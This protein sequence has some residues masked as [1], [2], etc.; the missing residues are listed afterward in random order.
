VLQRG[1]NDNQKDNQTEQESAKDVQLKTSPFGASPLKADP[2]VRQTV[3]GQAKL[4]IGKANDKYEVE[5]DRV[6]DKVVSKNNA[7][8]PPVQKK[9]AGGP[10][11]SEGAKEEDVQMKSAPEQ[12]TEIQ[13]KPISDSITKGIQLKPI[14]PTEDAEV[15]KME[16]E[17]EGEAEVQTKLDAST[18]APE[19]IQ[20]AEA[21]AEE[22]DLQKTAIQTKC[23]SCGKEES[24][25]KLNIQQKCA[26]CEGE[27][28]SVQKMDAEL[29]GEA[30]VQTKLDASTEAPEN[31]QKAEAPAEESDLQKTAIQ[32]KCSSCGKTESAE[33]LNVQQKCSS[34]EGEEKSVQKMET[35]DEKSEVQTKS[36]RASNSGAD[37]ESSLKSSKGKGSAMDDNTRS[38]MESG[39]GADFSGVRIH[40]DS[41]A[42]QMNK[43]LGSQAFAN[44]SD[45]YFNEGKYNPSSNSGQHLLAHELTHTV[46]QG[47]SPKAVQQKADEVQRQESSTESEQ[48]EDKIQANSIQKKDDPC[49]PP[50]DP[51]PVEKGKYN[52][53][54]KAQNCNTCY[55]TPIKPS[56]N[57]PEP[58]GD[59]KKKDVEAKAA[60]SADERQKAAPN[61]R[62]DSQVNTT[63]EPAP[64]TDPKKICEEREAKQQAKEKAKGKGAGALL[65][66]AANAA[67]EG[68]EAG[69]KGKK[70]KK[71][72]LSLSDLADQKS[73]EKREP[74]VPKGA[75]ASKPLVIEKNRNAGQANA[76][77]AQA[78]A[79][80]N[81][82]LGLGSQNVYFKPN[83]NGSSNDVDQ[84]ASSFIKTRSEKAAETIQQGHASILGV[85]ELTSKKKKVLQAEFNSKRQKSKA[86]FGIK[87]FQATLQ[88]TQSKLS[89]HKQYLQTVAQIQMKALIDSMFLRMKFQKDSERIAIE[90]KKYGTSVDA[91]FKKSH[92]QHISKGNEY[93]LKSYN[94]G[95]TMSQEYKHANN[96]G[97]CAYDKNKVKKGDADGF[98]D[99]YLTINRYEAR[100]ESALETGKQYQEGMQTQSRDVADKL[101]CQ[102]P[103][104]MMLAD[105]VMELSTN[106]LKCA[107]DDGLDAIDLRKTEALENASAAKEEYL[108]NLDATLSLTLADLN[109]KDEVQDAML[110]DYG[111]RQ[112]IALENTSNKIM[113]GLM[114]GLSSQAEQLLAQIQEYAASFPLRDAPD[115][116]TFEAE[117]LQFTNDFDASQLTVASAVSE[118]VGQAKGAI[119]EADGKAKNAVKSVYDS[120]IEQGTAF[121]DTFT[122]LN[123]GITKNLTEFFTQHLTTTIA[124]LQADYDGT[125]VRMDVVVEHA[126]ATFTGLLAD[127]DATLKNS[128]DGLVEGMEKSVEEKTLRAEICNQAEMAADEVSPWWVDVAMV[129]LYIIVIVVVIVL[130]VVTA[131][132]FAAV[133]AFFFGAGT[134]LAATT[135]LVLAGAAMGALSG[136]LI[137]VGTNIIQK[138]SKGELTWEGAFEGAG[139]EAL[140]GLIAGGIGG[141]AGPFIGTFA[142]KIA[143]LGKYG[144]I[145]LREG[146]EFA[147]DV[148]GAIVGDVVV[149][150]EVTSWT[151]VFTGAFV[152]RGVNLG[153][154]KFKLGPKVEKLIPDKIKINKDALKGQ[155]EF[156]TFR[157][158]GEVPAGGKVE[159]GG[160][161]TDTDTKV[162]TDTDTKVKSEGGAEWKTPPRTAGEIQAKNAGHGE[163]PPGHQWV[164]GKNGPYI[165]RQAG[166]DGPKMKLDAEGG[167]KTVEAGNYPTK[168]KKVGDEVDLETTRTKN[169]LTP[170]EFDLEMNAVNSRLPGKKVD[171]EHEGIRYKE[172]VELP[173]GHKWRRRDDGGWC[174]F[175]KRKCYP[176]GKTG[177]LN[178]PYWEPRRTLSPDDHGLKSHARK[179][180]DLSP[181]EYFK[182]GLDN[183]THGHSVNG[184][185][186]Y[187]GSKYYFR[188]VGDNLYSMTITNKKGGITSIDTWMKN[189][190][191]GKD[192]ILKGLKSSGA[193]PK[194]DFWNYFE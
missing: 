193:T 61:N 33:K 110:S 165:R 40:T 103:K 189:G 21:P 70:G 16:A 140:I 95:K 35:P 34:C 79:I 31:I 6:A 142:S 30:E 12:E 42:V 149:H 131:G 187:K 52:K 85:K 80:K 27:E 91:K 170:D 99:G 137:K 171:F 41:N 111:V 163:A 164:K 39:F 102:K 89:L 60:K 166:Y 138:G 14:A 139:K 65:K 44:G 183:I 106:N 186:K 121:F 81:Q 62:D 90:N 152:S 50:K 24:P 132:A 167:F 51:E 127:L 72:N 101:D 75:L 88:T 116:P 17:P 105:G 115:R 53:I 69:A 71:K 122:Q 56:E 130:T 169:D 1:Q 8:A 86:F 87:R 178:E 5:A 19:N 15:Q 11:E 147:F 78:L 28:K 96:P 113:A 94:L 29:E 13:E 190:N 23:S 162:K 150:G 153:T 172:E 155:F 43:S 84:L 148:V 107:M 180:S 182:R 188:K 97:A 157:V 83:E 118:I 32:T 3:F 93:G 185:G 54:T 58:E 123:D 161:K 128:L 25:E 77:G 126:L 48:K 9:D 104:R 117:M 141:F 7:P 159:T 136:F 175:S 67:K 177:K 134:A 168:T 18:E 154:S 47:A 4:N 119:D 20:K 174:R 129:L 66:G 133:G 146:V 2:F 45:V 181:K 114:Q 22:S 82:I 38:S 26:S 108:K 98:W 10:K 36:D 55:T 135:A 158:K 68:G 92:A 64:G 144:V 46:Q 59:E 76:A 173:N 191:L 100:A 74:L 179:H 156:D 192:E 151:S 73:K 143:P 37:V 124:G 125:V 194:K 184:S 63:E 49:A 120:G 112:I 145:A 160:V 176:L 109:E 57:E